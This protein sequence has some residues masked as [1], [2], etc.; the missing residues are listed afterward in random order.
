MATVGGDTLCFTDVAVGS[1]LQKCRRRGDELHAVAWS[2][3]LHD[4]GAHLVATGGAWCY[5]FVCFLLLFFVLYR[6]RLLVC[7]DSWVLGQ[8]G[9]ITVIDYLQAAVTRVIPA[10]QHAVTALCFLASAPRLLFS[11]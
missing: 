8:R 1:V 3:A 6:S 9:E 11:A 2:P 7:L 4:T 5:F 10:H